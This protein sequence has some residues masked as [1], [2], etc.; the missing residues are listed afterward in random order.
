LGSGG[1]ALAFLTSALDGHD[2][3]A[4]SPE[5]DSQISIQEE[6]LWK[7]IKGNS[8]LQCSVIYRKKKTF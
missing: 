4:L 7:K 3:S 1:I 2:L 8:V 5:K 6:A